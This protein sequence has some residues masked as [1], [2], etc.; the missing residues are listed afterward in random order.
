ML[1]ERRLFSLALLRRPRLLR[2]PVISCSQSLCAPKRSDSAKDWV[3][4]LFVCGC[5]LIKIINKLIAKVGI[6]IE[7]Y[8]FLK[9]QHI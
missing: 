2:M 4:F 3:E 5:H 6:C 9:M 1:Q 7:S 8:F